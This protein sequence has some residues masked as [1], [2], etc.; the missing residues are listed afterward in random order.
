MNSHFFYVVFFGFYFF[1]LLLVFFLL[2][3]LCF[4]KF[5][6]FVVIF[7]LV[8]GI[9]LI[10]KRRKIYRFLNHEFNVTTRHLNSEKNSSISCLSTIFTLNVKK[11]NYKLLHRPKAIQATNNGYIKNQTV[12]NQY[13]NSKKL[14]EIDENDGYYIMNLNHSSKHLTPFAYKRLIELGKLFRSK[15]ENEHEKKSYFV[16]SSVLRDEHQQ[17][18]V[19]NSN[20][21]T[22][23]KGLSTHSFGVAFDIMMLKA[24]HNCSDGLNALSQALTKMQKENKILLCT[25]SSCI[26]VTVI[27]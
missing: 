6:I 3:K 4:T 21:R 15:I 5:S 1:C 16:I 26:H 2:R 25:E 27:K 14:V 7:G 20:S 23:T 11:D 22:A 12:L 13:L 10:S 8:L 17:K 18:E 24:E 9:F 19:L